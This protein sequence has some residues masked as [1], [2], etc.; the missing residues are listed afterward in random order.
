MSNDYAKNM[1]INLPYIRQFVS[2]F[3]F[4]ALNLEYFR[5]LMETH[6]FNE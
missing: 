4:I 1:Y 2:L 5:S 6:C 3:C